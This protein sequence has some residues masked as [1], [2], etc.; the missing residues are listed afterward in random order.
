MCGY[1]FVIRKF[2]V[3][4]Q[5]VLAVIMGS[6]AASGWKT[7]ATAQVYSPHL[8]NVDYAHFEKEGNILFQESLQLVQIR[9]FALARSRMQLATQL[10][11]QNAKAWAFLGGLYLA[12]DKPDGALSA[13]LKAQTLDPKDASVWFRLGNVYFQKKDYGQAIAAFQS[14]LALK[15][16]TPGALFDMG[17]AFLMQR[18]AKEA[19]AVYEKAYASDK[20]FWY[21]L[22]NIGLIRYEAGNL[23]EAVRL[24]RSILGQKSNNP[25]R[26]AAKDEPRLALAVALYR[27]G[28]RGEALT[29]AQEV[30]RSDRRYG[31]IKFLKDNLWGD[32]LIADTQKLLQE[33][34]VQSALR[35]EGPPAPRP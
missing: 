32:R 16:D 5:L 24:W 14:G 1:R 9:Q 34:S 26:E 22:N 8:P 21:P 20:D 18:K 17:N 7:A 35:E 2:G 11:P 4:G 23:R 15:P 10:I 30:L 25:E 29:L 31:E 13:L 28:N 6:V 12:E 19:I 27:Q 33:D 3:K